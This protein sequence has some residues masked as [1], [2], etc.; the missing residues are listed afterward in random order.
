MKKHICK[1]CGKTYEYCRGCLLSPISYKENGYCS[2]TCQEAF[3]NK[4]E[5]VVPVEDVEVVVIEEDTSTPIE[6]AIEYPYFFTAT[7]E[8][9]IE[10]K[11]ENNEDDYIENNWEDIRTE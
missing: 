11:E 6:E 3:K 1:Q 9:V 7:E 2:L 5:E 8:E 4:I 10:E